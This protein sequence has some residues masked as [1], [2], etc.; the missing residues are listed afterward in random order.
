MFCDLHCCL[1]VAKRHCARSALR[2]TISNGRIFA[3]FSQARR[4]IAMVSTL[5]LSSSRHRFSKGTISVCIELCCKPV[6]MRLDSRRFCF[7]WSAYTAAVID[8]WKL[9]VY[10]CGFWDWSMCNFW[11]L[12]AVSAGTGQAAAWRLSSLYW[13]VGPSMLFRPCSLLPP[14]LSSWMSC[15]AIPKTDSTKRNWLTPVYMGSQYGVDLLDR[16]WLYR[17]MQYFL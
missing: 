15:F 1:A 11:V 5:M 9:V 8:C 14:W 4:L 7:D 10:S 17:L 2:V 6:T 3:Q 12:S 16:L 13:L